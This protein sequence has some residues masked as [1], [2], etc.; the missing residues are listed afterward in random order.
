MTCASRACGAVACAVAWIAVCGPASAQAPAARSIFPNLESNIERPLRYRPHGGDFVIVNGTESF[1]R[2]LYGR[3]TAFRVDAGDEPEF[4]LYLPGRGGN[5]RL[6]V[7]SGAQARW[8]TDAARVTARY[9]PG[10]MIHE[11]EDPL[12]GRGAMLE[13]HALALHETDGLI[14]QFTLHSKASNPLPE[15]IV[16]Y[17]GVNGERGVRDGDI[18]TERV[19]ISEWFQLA[20]E[21][22]RDN[23]IDVSRNSFELRSAAAKIAGVFPEGSQLSIADAERWRDAALLAASA[24]AQT[25]TPVLLAAVALPRNQPGYFAL[26]VQPRAG[27]AVELSTYR[28]VTASQAAPAA[29]LEQV[30]APYSSQRLP[31]VFERTQGHFRALRSRV[32]VRTPDPYLDAAVGALNVAA[33]ASW[34]EPQGVVMHGAIAW[35]AR[36]LGWRGAYAMDALGWHDRARRHLAYWSTRQNTGPIPARIPPAEE[37]TNLARNPAAIHS[38]GDL[39]NSHYDMNLVYIDALFRHLLWTGDLE[40]AREVWPVIERHLAWERRLFRREFGPQ[41]LPLYEG[42]AAIWASD[43]L[44]YHG[45]GTTHASAYNWWHNVMAARLARLLGK[46]PSPF[47]REAELI[48][49]A[50]EEHLWLPEQGMFAEYRDYLGAQRAHPAAALWSFYLVLDAP[51]LVDARRAWQMSRYVDLHLPHLPVRGPGIAG[52]RHHVLATSNWMP[53]TWSIN[54]VVMGENLHAALAFWQAQRPAEAFTLLRSAILASMYMG[55][56]P[57]NVGTMNYLDVYRRES[58]RD[59]ADGGGVMARALVEGLFGVRPDALAGEIVIAP[60]WPSEWPRVELASAALDLRFER[61]RRTD[62]YFV[63]V[64]SAAFRRGRLRLPLSHD[65]ARVTSAG[66]ELPAAI[67]AD[68]LGRRWVEVEWKLADAAALEVHWLGRRRVQSP[69]ALDAAAGVAQSRAV[70]EPVSACAPP[71]GA[72]KREAGFVA[73]GLAEHFNDRLDQIFVR[74]KYRSPRSPFASLAMPAQGI[75]A[76]AGHVHELPQIDDSGLRAAAAANG[77]RFVLPNRVPFELPSAG[78]GPNVAF[79]SRWDNHPSSI[80]IPLRGRGSCLYLLMAGSTNHMQS[81]FD[82]AE[83]VVEYADG[84]RR[85]LALRNPTNWWPIDQDYFIDDFQFRRPG[86]I[87]MRVD[88][89]TGAVRS[90][91]AASFAGSGGKI[92]GGA[93][94]VLEMPLDG[95]RELRSL[96]VTAIANEVIVGLLGLTLAN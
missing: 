71:A 8:L 29:T 19:P 70:E 49:R 4:V 45:G 84:E 96:T 31:A 68:A 90:P 9:R 87:P 95:A 44:Q 48:R 55:I 16:A 15:L 63:G 33:D 93:A 13:I 83:L 36:L 3:N 65:G 92:G 67:V 46:D 24:G 18:G 94:T 74:G 60:G 10:E 58:Q 20:P 59:F 56:A 23:A 57:G 66:R 52:P 27:A 35:R 91:D 64:K 2:P 42:Y 77:G 89:R 54:N 61:R 82:N 80:A 73:I 53:Y 17:G 28:D 76:W 88:L 51:G 21:F 62:R 5:L 47:E 37:A 6:G 38:N 78:A 12:L 79:V 41:R 34:D 75:G 50:M 72:P 25:R 86:R 81:R 26:Q 7:R 11:I 32:Q 14:L 43:D 1:N 40:F 85:G 39:S 22:C 69:A 30:V